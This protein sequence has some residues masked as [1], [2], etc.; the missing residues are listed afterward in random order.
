MNCMH[1]PSRH[2]YV[3][4]KV[5]TASYIT[6]T[7]LTLCV[8]I[9][10][11]PVFAVV[12][13]LPAQAATVTD[14][15][16][17]K[18]ELERQ[19]Q[20]AARQAKE[21]KSVAERAKDKINDLQEQISSL[22]SSITQTQSTIGETQKQI[23]EKNQE[24]ARLESEKRRI[25]DQQ[26]ALIR[27][28]YIMSVS[29][30]PDMLLFSSDSLSNR[31]SQ[32]Q[33][34]A[35]L[36][37]SVM[38]LVEKTNAA[39]LAVEQSRSALIAKNNQLEQLRTQQ[40]EQKNGLASMQDDQEA[41]KQNAESAMA[42]L[43]EKAKKARMEEARIE[44]QISAALTAAIRARSGKISSATAGQRVRKGDIIGHLGST[45]NSTGPHVHFEVRVNNR[46]VNPRPYVGNGTL[47]WPVSNYRVSQN[48]G[49]CGNTSFYEC[50]TGID[51]AGPYGQPVYAPA[52]GTVIL[53]QWYGGYGNAWAEELDNG[54]VVLLGHMTGS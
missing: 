7:I 2:T 42:K 24:V 35:D 26:G 22:S 4:K 30:S 47:S 18:A 10:G 41:L 9:A 53:K 46:A 52:D 19:A 20:Q 29:Y 33:Q 16:K 36:Q 39:K 3:L 48:F 28:M 5:G 50:H 38:Q 15:N 21:Q 25:M 23:D 37:K 6:F 11:L 27:Q 32:E 43:E 31:Q 8:F 51:L 34:F 17:K 12:K 45:G 44:A 13:P 49:E 14:L 40:S 1:M 54:L